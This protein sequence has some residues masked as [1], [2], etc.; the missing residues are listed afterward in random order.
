M[1]MYVKRKCSC[2]SNASCLSQDLLLHNL[3]DLEELWECISVHSVH[4]QTWIRE[5]DTTLEQVEY[6]RGNLVGI[7]EDLFKCNH[8]DMIVNFSRAATTPC[9]KAI[10]VCLVLCTN[11][12]PI[13]LIIVEK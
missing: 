10:N 2:L 4:R 11:C 3:A 13:R 7:T 8:K 1:Q 9:S 5:L 12:M 6:D